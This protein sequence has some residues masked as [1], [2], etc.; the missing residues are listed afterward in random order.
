MLGLAFGSGGWLAW[1]PAEWN[2]PAFQVVLVVHLVAGGLSLVLYLFYVIVHLR[3]TEGSVLGFLFP[4]R[5]FG[6]GEDASGS[7]FGK[8]LSGHLL[9]WHTLAAHLTGVAFVIPALL[10]YPGVI[11]MA[12]KSAYAGMSWAHLILSILTAVFW[13]FHLRRVPMAASGLIR[14]R[15][16]G[17]SR[18]LS[19]YAAGSVV[20]VMV[21]TVVLPQQGSTGLAPGKDLPYYSLPW[22]DDPY[23]PAE[24]KTTDGKLI[25]WRR[26]PSAEV[27]GECHKKE[28]REWVSSIHA[29]TGP[30]VIYE[31][32]IITN[33]LDS[34]AGGATATEKIRWCDSCHEPLGI[35]AGGGSPINSV[36]P[37][38]AL[39]EGASC[40]LC[41]TAVEA[42]PLAGNGG[43]TVALNEL[44]RHIDP[45]LIMAAPQ[46]HA[47][48]MQAVSS[49]P[50]MASSDMCGACH[51]EIRPPEVNGQ[52]AMHLQDTYDEWRRTSYAREGIQCQNCHMTPDPADY[53]ARLKKGERPERVVS[54]R[55]VGNNYLLTDP[56][57]PQTFLRGGPPTGH[58]TLLTKKEWLEDLGRQQKLILALLQEAAD[59]KAEAR[60]GKDGDSLDLAVTITNS[61]AGHHLPTGPLDQ[62]YMWLEVK[63]NDSTGKTVF[64]SGWFDGEKGYEDPDAVKYL[65]ILY[66]KDGNHIRNHVLFDVDRLEYTR[67]PIPA[68]QS[69]RIPYTVPLTDAAPDGDLTVEV[70]LWYRLALQDIVQN[71]RDKF[72]AGFH[73]IIPPVL[74]EE[75]TVT[76]PSPR[77]GQAALNVSPAEVSQ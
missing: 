58:N 48:S 30:D 1:A 60:P 4:F 40:I 24:W 43:L 14:S 28:F 2:W 5:L 26:V 59:L 62:R 15:M 19:Y 69:D 47:R 21:L 42:R 64:H 50:M 29:V 61:G 41:H 68:G 67:K 55:F 72:D 25:D 76:V 9:H 54:H 46:Q 56:S 33:E 71:I 74:M 45:A 77:G 37:N 49:N 75:T 31:S 3:E 52:S 35:L 63:V 51:T 18:R 16:P 38:E 65:K 6:G 22:G 70:R 73:A 10:W 17:A 44:D 20:A 53:V 39:E 7:S 32:T 11:V 66:D 36:G 23:F 8:R 57:L 27:C 13:V 34:H 12:G